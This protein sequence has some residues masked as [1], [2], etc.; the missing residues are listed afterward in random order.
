MS[1][2]TSQSPKERWR[3]VYGISR[4]SRVWVSD[5]CNVR[6]QFLITE[7]PQT[8]RP[9]VH[10]DGR[11]VFV[12]SLALSTFNPSDPENPDVPLKP[13]LHTP[14]SPL[15]VVYID[16]DV[17][18]KSLDNLSWT[19]I[20][21]S[22]RQ[23]ENNKPLALAVPKDESVPDAQTLARYIYDR[24]VTPEMSFNEEYPIME[25]FP[26]DVL[27]KYV[28][29]PENN[30]QDSQRI[31]NIDDRVDDFIIRLNEAVTSMGSVV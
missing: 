17:S 24:T 31:Q 2:T 11:P 10:I 21:L 25:T 12:D 7:D 13:S 9:V 4:T 15:E 16:G 22:S 26:Q 28:D 14:D 5:Q 30:N 23:R 29:V 3:E 18:H 20:P 6:A 1:T 27:Q 8:S 19:S